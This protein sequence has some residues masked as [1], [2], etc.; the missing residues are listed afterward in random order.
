MFSIFLSFKKSNSAWAR[1]TIG[2]SCRRHWRRQINCSI[3]FNIGST[4]RTIVLIIQIGWSNF[5]LPLP[6][7][8]IIRMHSTFAIGI[9]KFMH[10]FYQMVIVAEVL[11]EKSKTNKKNMYVWFSNIVGQF[12]NSTISLIY[13]GNILVQFGSHC[14]FKSIQHIIILNSESLR[15]G[16][17]SR[18]RS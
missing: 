6:T 4:E 12:G 8:T 11:I 17:V 10:I 18:L 14:I 1:F 9:L 5:N 7:Y 16:N 2:S 13:F 3:G 15:N